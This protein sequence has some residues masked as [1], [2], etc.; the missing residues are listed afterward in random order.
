MTLYERI[1]RAAREAKISLTNL[2]SACG[3]SNGAIGKWKESMPKADKLYSVAHYLGKTVEY[4]LC[5][6]DAH[7]SRNNGNYLNN[8]INES[9]NSHL[10]INGSSSD[11]TKQELELLL[12]YRELGIKEQAEL[13][14]VLLN[15]KK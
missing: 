8:S 4:F 2:E 1:E 14:T 12:T 7:C 10:I 3:L 9:P 15:L 6:E 11:L 5:G 13:I